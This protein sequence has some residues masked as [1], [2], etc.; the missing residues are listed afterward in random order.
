MLLYIK[1]SPMTT[2]KVYFLFIVVIPSTYPGVIYKCDTGPKSQLC[3]ISVGTVGSNHGN[4]Y[5]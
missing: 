5:T 1:W 2:G 4:L 3:I